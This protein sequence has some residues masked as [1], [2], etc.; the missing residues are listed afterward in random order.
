MLKLCI[1][2]GR[3]QSIRMVFGKWV[4]MD[5]DYFTLN[6]TLSES[7]SGMVYVGNTEHVVKL[8]K[9]IKDNIRR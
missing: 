8:N 6:V 7:S 1:G 2:S 3:F 4:H 5:T 9:L